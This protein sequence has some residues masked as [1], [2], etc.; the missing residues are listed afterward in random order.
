MPEWLYVLTVT[1]PAMLT[2]GPDAREGAVLADHF[3]YLERLVADGAL[4]LAGRTLQNDASTM[5]LAV[6]RAPDEA[7]A[8][9]VMQA[10]PA[11]RDG[12]MTA[13]LHPFRVALLGK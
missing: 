10:D 11:V 7:A 12:V 2:E 9:A 13:V 3:A 4:V 8:R 5:G 1:R 6:L